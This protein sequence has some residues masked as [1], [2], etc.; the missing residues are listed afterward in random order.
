MPMD[1]FVVITKRKETT[2]ECSW[3]RS[4]AT[5]DN[6]QSE[7]KLKGFGLIA[8]ITVLAAWLGLLYWLILHT[9]ATDAEWARL[10]VVLGS[11]EAVAFGAAGA[12]FGTT[13]QRQRVQEAQERAEK[14]EGRAEKAE[15]TASA[16]A[17]AATN[18]KA[19]AAAVKVRERSRGAA[20]GIERVTRGEQ[21]GRRADDALVEFAQKLFPD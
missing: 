16:T 1:I 15:E 2:F 4:E 12:L 20:E 3:N 5:M 11:L 8:A 7:A 21:A 19:L 13:I 18:G 6:S 9:S 17:A 10:L 14:A